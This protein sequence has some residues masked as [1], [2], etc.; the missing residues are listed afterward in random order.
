[1]ADG[2]HHVVALAWLF[3]RAGI[4]EAGVPTVLAQLAKLPQEAR[5]LF[6]L[7]YAMTA[8]VMWRAKETGFRRAFRA[9]S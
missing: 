3:H 2:V 8:Y 1:M 6:L 4:L 9:E 7:P 5:M